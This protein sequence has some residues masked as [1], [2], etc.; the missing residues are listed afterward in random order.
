MRKRNGN[1]SVRRL[2][3]AVIAAMLTCWVAAARAQGIGSTVDPTTNAGVPL[4]LG[5]S[6]RAGNFLIT[7]L[8][9]VLVAVFVAVLGLGIV[10]FLQSGGEEER[11]A[12]AKKTI[13]IGAIGVVVVLG[14]YGVAY[15]VFG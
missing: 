1:L 11:A 2:G 13:V 6:A 12:A 5:S 15:L 14:L 7:L 3:P 8:L 4:G 9:W 10:R